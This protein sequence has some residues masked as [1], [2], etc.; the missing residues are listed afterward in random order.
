MAKFLL[1]RKLSVKCRLSD[2]S[3]KLRAEQK[4]S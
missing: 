1:E 3:W 4:E 2:I